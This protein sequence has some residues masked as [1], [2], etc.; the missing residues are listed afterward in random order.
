MVP[1]RARPSLHDSA[2]PASPDPLPPPDVRKLRHD[3]RGCMHRM[4]LCLSALETPLSREDYLAFV[5]DIAAAAEEM[6]EL[7]DRLDALPEA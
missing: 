3:L 1:L 4:A 5:E 7:L 2:H 6:G